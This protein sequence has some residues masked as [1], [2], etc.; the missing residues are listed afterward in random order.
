MTTSDSR[1]VA[2]D[3]CPG[4]GRI[5]IYRVPQSKHP[6][7]LNIVYPSSSFSPP[8]EKDVTVPW[9]HADELVYFRPNNWSEDNIISRLL[10]IVFAVPPPDPQ[11]PESTK[12]T[13]YDNG[14]S[15][16][17]YIVQ[18]PS[19][20]RINCLLSRE[21]HLRSIYLEFGDKEYK[22]DVL[23]KDWTSWALDG[24]KLTRI[25]LNNGIDV[26]AL[27]HGLRRHQATGYWYWD[28]YLEPQAVSRFISYP[29][30][31]V[32]AWSRNS[33]PLACVPLVYEGESE[34]TFQVDESG[35]AVSKVVIKSSS[36]ELPPSTRPPKRKKSSSPLCS[37]TVP[38]VNN[39]ALSSV[40]ESA[41]L[42]V[43]KR[44][45][46]GITNPLQGWQDLRV[47]Q[48]KLFETL[49]G[50]LSK[51]SKRLSLYTLRNEPAQ[52][53]V[54]YLSTVGPR[55]GRA[56]A[57]D[58]LYPWLRKH[59]LMA[60]RK[61]CEASLLYPQPYTLTNIHFDIHKLEGAGGFCDIVKGEQDGKALCLKVVRIHGKSEINKMLKVY[62]KE[63]VLWGHLHHVN[64]VPFYGIY[65]IND[66][67]QRICLVSPWMDN[68]N[69]V[70]YLERKPQAA[71]KPLI[72]DIICGL[73]YL[74]NED[75]VHGDLKGVNVLVDK[76]GRAC[77]ADFGLSTV[78]TSK[79]LGFTN[80]TVGISGR[81]N[82]WAAPELLDE[83]ARATRASDIWAFGCVCYEVL[84]RQ[85]PFQSTATDVQVIRKLLVG[86]KPARAE[87]YRPTSPSDV[88]DDGF[89]GLMERCWMLEPDG[90]PSCQQLLQELEKSFSIGIHILGNLQ[91]WVE[92]S[93]F[94]QRAGDTFVASIDLDQVHR[95][96]RAL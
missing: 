2:P 43:N 21:E 86:E 7:G 57:P 68:G 94:R 16:R 38:A 71:R 28:H 25:N 49:S 90:R 88:I 74:H 35:I 34:S 63:A 3:P 91:R 78:W 9:V 87:G 89:W 14:D 61:L 79:T 53:V 13:L 54:N 10:Q 24:R 75:I 5:P 56:D 73:L 22:E 47:A 45:K 59:S 41:T 30:S 33:P 81:T 77:L 17:H 4:D 69:V 23:E 11:Q 31:N 85:V 76:I 6:T 82:R 92:D 84:T 93:E 1:L 55:L 26:R 83:D 18:I 27:I 8:T 67:S 40:P 48:L 39:P 44:A 72:A 50:V 15:G 12:I 66:G 70:I 42:P 29:K 20:Y 65:N 95:V 32:G 96:L 19:G 64:I 36:V 60:L 58:Q 52:L 62:A 80:T 51:K 46:S 37:V